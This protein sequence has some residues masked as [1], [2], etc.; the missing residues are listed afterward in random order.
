[1]KG[2]PCSSAQLGWG[3][4]VFTLLFNFS[5]VFLLSSCFRGGT[6]WE[7]AWLTVQGV[8]APR[9]SFP[10]EISSW[11]APG[12]EEEEQG[13]ERHRHSTCSCS[14]CRPRHSPKPKVQPKSKDFKEILGKENTLAR[15]WV[16]KFFLESHSLR[17]TLNMLLKHLSPALY[18]SQS[19]L[20]FSLA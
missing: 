19:K 18:Q 8:C 2:C 4:Q 10:E 5:S 3:S 16:G 20:S 9:R 6:S 1:M 14:C 17:T 11:D 15:K 13:E 7:P 12:M